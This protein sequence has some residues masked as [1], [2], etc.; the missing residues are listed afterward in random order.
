M[1]EAEYIVVSNRA[2]ISLMQNAV[3]GMLSGEGT[4]ISDEHLKTLQI[5]LGRMAVTVWVDD[6]TA[7]DT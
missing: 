5:T 6:L 1:T 4:G 2:H 3:H 7:E